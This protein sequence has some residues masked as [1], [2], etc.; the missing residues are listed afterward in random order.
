[1]TMLI[2]CLASASLLSGGAFPFS[3]HL[4]GYS[5]VNLYLLPMADGPLGKT[6]KNSKLEMSKIHSNK[7]GG[8]K[9]RRDKER[10]KDLRT[11]Y[12]GGLT[13]CTRMN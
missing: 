11:E 1:M 10:E 9:M 12:K 6:G 13:L 8:I 2:L 3:N 7:K 5:D 4:K